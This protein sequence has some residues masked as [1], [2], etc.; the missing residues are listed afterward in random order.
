MSG[1]GGVCVE[2]ALGFRVFGLR[3]V[4]G[5]RDVAGLESLRSVVDVTFGQ[6]VGASG[7]CLGFIVPAPDGAVSTRLPLSAASF[8]SRSETPPAY[9]PTCLSECK[10]VLSP[11]LSPAYLSDITFCPPT[12]STPRRL[13]VPCVPPFILSTVLPVFGSVCPTKRLVSPPSLLI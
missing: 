7:R 13:P 3:S 4:Y 6:E 11:S 10:C 9:L 5:G 2:L 12:A 1:T 8:A